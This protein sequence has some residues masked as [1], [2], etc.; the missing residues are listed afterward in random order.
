MVSCGR[1]ILAFKA[2]LKRDGPHVIGYRERVRAI[3][4]PD[5]GSYCVD[6]KTGKPGVRVPDNICFGM[7]EAGGF[8]KTH[9]ATGL[10]YGVSS[11]M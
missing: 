4:V 7:V 2:S 5:A 6:G 10:F 9:G 1:R 11:Q 3:S 8:G